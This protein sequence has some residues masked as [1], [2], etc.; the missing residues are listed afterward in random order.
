MASTAVAL[1]APRRRRR[2]QQQRQQP[3]WQGSGAPRAKRFVGLAY[4]ATL[5]TDRRCASTASASSARF[6]RLHPR[7]GARWHRAAA[8]AIVTLGG[9]AAARPS[10]RSEVAEVHAESSAAR[11]R[12]DTRLAAAPPPPPGAP[13]ADAARRARHAA[14]PSSSFLPRGADEA[15]LRRSFAA[16][17]EITESA[18]CSTTSTGRSQQCAFVTYADASSSGRPSPRCTARPLLRGAEWAIVVRRK[19]V[20]GNADR[21]NKARVSGAMES[22]R[23]R[24]LDQDAGRWDVGMSSARTSTRR[25]SR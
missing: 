4:P 1:M 3:E 15:M 2:A 22:K 8:R 13:A 20:R 17:G 16:F 23:A 11:S 7:R 12:C 9:G 5:A 25:C 6:A 10:R 21:H 24:A 19:D 18:S 14:P